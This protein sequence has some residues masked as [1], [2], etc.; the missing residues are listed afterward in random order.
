MG[1]KKL[2]VVVIVELLLIG[3]VSFYANQWFSE[4]MPRHQLIQ[5]PAM[6]L[7]GM[8][9]GWQVSRFSVRDIFVGV[10]LLIFVM[11]SL[12]FWMLP[13]SIDVAVIYP[14][15]NRIMHINMFLCGWMI[16][17]VWRRS[18]F[19]IKILFSGMMASVLMATGIALQSFEILLCSSF[20][21]AQQKETGFYLVG[22]GVLL[23]AYTLSVLFRKEKGS[24]QVSISQKQ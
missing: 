5:L 3:W 24:F 14:L 2:M 6:V 8:A 12:I 19:E 16:V 15:V 4:T 20:N 17:I 11:A 21:I 13:L 22:A 23:F 10:G 9:G 1:N 18:R 7:L